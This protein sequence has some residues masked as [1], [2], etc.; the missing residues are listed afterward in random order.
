M[1]DVCM[2]FHY[3]IG[4][5]VRKTEQHRLNIVQPGVKS[6]SRSETIDGVGQGA[7]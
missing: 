7:S 5:G 1:V 6:R 2:M 3:P 4:L